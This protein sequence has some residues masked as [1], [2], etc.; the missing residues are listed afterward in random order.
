MNSSVRCILGFCLF[1]LVS[2]CQHGPI[3]SESRGLDILDFHVS[4][5]PDLQTGVVYGVQKIMIR[6]PKNH[7]ETLSFT[8]G[9][10]TVTE[11]SINGHRVDTQLVDG[12]LVLPLVSTKKPKEL[13]EITAKYSSKPVRGYT[14]DKSTL[15]TEYFSCDWMIC[16]QENFGDKATVTLEL[17]LPKKME[18]IGP[19]KLLGSK[20]LP[21][22]LHQSTWRS[23]LA[24]SPYLYAFAFGDFVTVKQKSGSVSLKYMSTVVDEDALLHLFA[25]TADMLSF[26]EEKAGTPFPHEEYTQL[27]VEGRS[28]QEAVSHS[29][30]GEASLEL[31]LTDPKEDWVIAHELAHQWWGNGVTCT[32]ISEFWLNEGITTFMVA[33]WKEHRWGYA[34]Y[35][36]ELQFAKKRYQRAIDAGMDV[37]LAYDGKYPSLGIRR[38]IQYSKGAIFMDILRSELGDEA[39]WAGLRNY[40]IKNMGKTVSS[41]DLQS[42]FERESKMDLSSLFDEWV[43]GKAQ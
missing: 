32:D 30:I 15:Y 34:A 22:G 33:A 2:A 35:E 16:Q 14:A 36:R 8:S 18:S 19:G 37:P 21:N 41:P 23:E 43:Y 27:Y 4:L 11:V 40:T 9:V 42:E 12:Q 31:I 5:T 25:P 39:F 38:N 1:S 26:F 13:I 6:L 10:I 29:V 28:A 17:N 7:P 3:S 24:Y 20:W